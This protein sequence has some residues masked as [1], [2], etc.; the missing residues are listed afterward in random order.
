VEFIDGLLTKEL[1]ESLL[2]KTNNINISFMVK[3][4]GN[5][6]DVH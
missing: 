3:W 1:L 4:Q 5:L 2:S 6:R